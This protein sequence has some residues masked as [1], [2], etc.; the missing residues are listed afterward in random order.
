MLMFYFYDLNCYLRLIKVNL[1]L[2]KADY[3]A[4]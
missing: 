2:C 3:V 4:S 1:A